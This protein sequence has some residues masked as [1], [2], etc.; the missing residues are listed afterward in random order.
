MTGQKY[1]SKWLVEMINQK[2]QFRLGQKVHGLVTMDK[3]KTTCPKW[4]GGL[5]YTSKIGLLW[6]KFLVKKIGIQVMV[7]QPTTCF[8]WSNMIQMFLKS[9]VIFM[10]QG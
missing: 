3:F 6:P 5:F 2:C 10:W 1:Q 9:L 8:T 7:I 4:L